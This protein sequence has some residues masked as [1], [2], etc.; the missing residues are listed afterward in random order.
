[1][2]V[3]GYFNQYTHPGQQNLF[4]SLIIESIQ[5]YGFNLIYLPRTNASVDEIFRENDQAI[6]EQA[7]VL[8]A[9]VKSV[10]GFAGDGKFMSAQLGWEIRD[11]IV[12]TVAQKTFGTQLP[13]L[14]RPR[15]GDLVYL[16]LD[17]KCYEI[18]FV[19][20]QAVFYQL[21]KLN[22]YDLT[23]ELLEYNGQM[24]RTGV[25]EIDQLETDFTVANL[26]EETTEEMDWMDQSE[27]VQDET[28]AVVDFDESDPF[29][30]GERL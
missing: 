13:E 19:N 3:N 14:L 28:P 30:F 15:E 10:D 5:I 29:S 2:A 1:M 8:E 27:E 18:K 17:K 9:Y 26:D 11:Q 24:F 21:G 20:H 23:C 22:T 7:V 6:F 4:E 12:F 16:P 25:S